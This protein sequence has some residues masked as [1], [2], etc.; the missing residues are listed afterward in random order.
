LRKKTLRDVDLKGRKVLMRV[1]FNVPLSK[2]GSIT[3]D[4]RVR[5]S[6]PSIDYIAAGGGSCVLMSH[7]GRPKGKKDKT[8]SLRPIA[9]CR[10]DL[11]KHPVRFVEDCVG[12]DAEKAAA[13]LRPGEILLLE[14]VR[15][16]A[17]EEAN[18]PEFAKRL[19]K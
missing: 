6:L 11:V 5:A 2:E 16:Y 4:T 17:E 9:D 7:L 18:D 8:Y 3:D 19:A 1:D 14:N 15:F 10:G 12:P 13:A